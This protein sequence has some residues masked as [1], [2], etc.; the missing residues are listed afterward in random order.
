MKKTNLLTYLMVLLFTPLF[1]Q[2]VTIDHKTQR[3]LGNSTSELDRTR[4]FTYHSLESDA[5][6]TKFMNDYNVHEG[7]RFWGPTGFAKHA[8]GSVGT[9]PG[10]QAGTTN[11]Q[12]RNVARHVATDHPRNVVRWNADKTA[13]ANWVVEYY[14]DWVDDANRPQ[15]YEPMNEPFVHGGDAV[16]SAEQPDYHKMIRRMAEWF[17]EFGKKI[18]EAPELSNMKVIGY[19]SAWP[20]ME[21]WDFNHW[22][23]R[24]KMFMDV[25]GDH[26]DAFATHL[27]DGVNVTGQNNARSGSN[28]E[29]ILDLIE[30]YSHI[31]WGYVKDHAITEYG[32][33]ASGYG[34]NYSDIESIQTVKGINHILFNLLERED[35]MAISIPFITG[36]GTWF[37]TPENNYQPYGAV[38]FR[39]TNL[40]Q[41]NPTGWVYTP[42]IYFY[43]MWKDVKGKR[44][45]VSSDNPDIQIQGFLDGNKL[46]VAL[47][48]LDGATKTVNLDFT[49]GLNN[50]QSVKTKSLKI[51]ANQMPQYNDITE[52]T[53]PSSVTLIAGETAVLEYTF[54]SNISFDN[55]IRRQKYYTNKYLQPINANATMTFNFNGVEVGDGR[56]FLRMSI[57]RKHNVSKKPEIKVNGTAINVP[58]NWKGYDQA[59]RT[60]FF[61]TIEI[62]V[63]VNLLQADNT[64]TIKF[65]DNGGRVAS[66]ILQKETL[67]NNITS[68]ATD[69]VSFF[70]APTVVSSSTPY[71]VLVNYNAT[72]SR[73]IQLEFW[74]AA[75]QLTS[76][77][78]TV[79]AGAGTAS[80]NVTLN[81]PATTTSNNY[82]KTSIRPQGSSQN[83][84]T[85]QLNN[86]T[87]IT[88]S[89]KICFV[90][91]PTAIPSTTSYTVEMSYSATQSRDL[92]LELWSSSGWLGQGVKTVT[93]GA[94]TT[95]MTVNLNTPPS[96]GTG[97]IWKASIRP[98]G[99][100]W[101]QSVDNKQVNNVTVL[102]SD[103]ISSIDADLTI[104]ALSTYTLDV[105]YTA[106]ET[107]DIVAEFWSPNG[108]LGFGKT[109][110]NAG[111]G[112]ATVTINLSNPPSSGLGYL[113]K[114]SI[115]PAGGDWTTAFD[116][117]HI[118]G[119]TV[120][121][122]V[123][124]VSLNNPPSTVVAQTTYTLD[125]DYNA[126]DARDVV[127]GLWRGSTFLKGA[128]TTV[129]V[130]AGTTAVTLNLDTPP[131]PDT[132][133]VWK[134]SIRP[135]GADFSQALDT[136]FKSNVT[137]L[138]ST[139]EVSFAS[140]P[141]TILA[142]T[143]YDLAVDYAA[144]Q[145]R[146]IVVEFW[147]PAGF[148]S[149]EITTVDAGVGTASITISLPNAPNAGTGY[150]WKASIRPVNT[151]W[152]Q[153]LDSENV[154]DVTVIANGD[155]IEFV[156]APTTVAPQT[157]YTFE[158]SY[159][160]PQTRDLA[161]SLW[162]GSSQL[163]E[164]TKTIAAGFGTTSITLDLAN[165]PTYGTNYTWIAS[166]R[167]QG[168][169]AA[170]NLDNDQVDNVLVKPAADEVSLGNAPI[171]IL[172]QTSY[173][174]EV[175]YAATA[176]REVVVEFWNG[177]GWIKEGRTTVN[178]GIGTAMVTINL[179]NAPS[180]GPGYIWKGSIRPVG[181]DWTTN[182]DFD[183]VNGVAVVPENDGVS[184]DNAPMTI[185]S[186]TAY[187]FD[188]AYEATE[189]RDVAVSLWDWDGVTMLGEG[190]LTVAGGIDVASVTLT[191]GSAPVPGTPYKWLAS[192]R[193]EGSTAASDIATELIDN[194]TVLPDY[195]AIAMVN[196][197]TTLTPQ[198]SYAVELSYGATQARE[199]VLGFWNGSTWL[200][201]TVD[202]VPAGIGDVTLTVDL[203]NAPSYGTNYIWKASIRPVGTTQWTDILDLDQVNNVSVFPANDEVSFVNAPTTLNP[204]TSY[205]I[206]VN[207]AA[208][209]SRDVTVSFWSGSNWISSN[210]NTVQA[211]AGITAVTIDLAN[212][213]SYG[214]DY[215]WVVTIRP[216]GG[217]QWSDNLAFEQVNNVTVLPSEDEIFLNAPSTLQPQMAYTVDVDY[218]ATQSRDVVV[219]FWN[220]TTWIAQGATT[221]AP[222]VGN[223]SVT[224][225][226]T[227]LPSYGVNYIWK[228]SIRP[229]G[230]DWTQN[231]DTDQINN[232]KLVPSDDK[233]GLNNAPMNVFPA[234]SYT[235]NVNYIASQSRD[236]VVEFWKGSNWLGQGM[237]T[238]TAGIGTVSV[239]I[240]LADTPSYGADYSWKA[241]IRPVGTDWTQNLGMDQV[242]NVLVVN[243]IFAK[244]QPTK[245][246]RQAEAEENPLAFSVYPNPASDF[247]NVTLEEANLAQTTVELFNIQGQKVYENTVDVG[248][249]LQIP[250]G[251]DLAVGMYLLKLVNGNE[252]R[253]Q[254]IMVR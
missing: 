89:D 136:D 36:K 148:L 149:N 25:A 57:G 192:I 190:V 22:N 188:I 181:G 3:F 145:A 108:Y 236:V 237:A 44:V 64:I 214:T 227:Y 133:Y 121:P 71:T 33:I 12:V 201:S 129:S 4:Y 95:S 101:T 47:N 32:A 96:V 128:S 19:S 169:T 217:T 154:Y 193:P 224:I 245:N 244:T 78:Q 208:T 131:T 185:P 28:S 195:D 222:G 150:Y 105:N 196:A 161:I 20:S 49:R 156:N 106:T 232:V 125:I 40:G 60:D 239:T 204:Q 212:A 39:P 240:N 75:G 9:Y 16:F 87:A 173:T 86:V 21:L 197:P 103:E 144:T 111:V 152:T 246:K 77:Q 8:T 135:L 176:T 6:F 115:R 199:V 243:D 219:E 252:I 46:Y 126:T 70:S 206:D 175:D 54:S 130:G 100:D 120:L 166:I 55:A 38:L 234:T 142:A 114:V 174:I 191:L 216:V 171:N 37:M 5:D 24:M 225:N 168:T 51:Y 99:T 247:V 97:Y 186:Q 81:L 30:S 207:Y 34:G 235:V 165:S 202:T 10:Y 228:A 238:V 93:A 233:I 104:P 179:D 61:G 143:S 163:G 138:P 162:D 254:K 182:L 90:E 76:L 83:L 210:V 69:D 102:G 180:Y 124:E 250:L 230:T 146:D 167:P 213:P 249:T 17:G 122:S 1:A 172:P 211:G 56:A 229:V 189:T 231:I 50:F 88:G 58:N 31:K 160:A 123:D 248:N 35:K 74:T 82:W 48:N 158:V 15:F 84:N 62:P 85:A 13:A 140:A 200:S 109:T 45:N 139:D 41:P 118:N 127:L 134:T 67:D 79:A 94:G 68:P 7:R 221:V 11:T 66:L 151:D 23:T 80:F 205:T 117:D 226:L 155:A 119:V 112:T 178:T 164:S 177:L 183:Q 98:V 92:V 218:A 209:Q 153:A 73:D 137:I 65:P 2:I 29:A 26:M 52:T 194:V 91:E 72:Q 170:D 110:V 203:A 27:Y 253:H 147:S 242:S 53:A 116:L 14:R 141:T 42:K 43:E 215:S 159:V 184:F 187:T 18:H 241:S 220:G 107:R 251:N 59:N 63:P 198:T 157:A 113:W 223:A 132:T